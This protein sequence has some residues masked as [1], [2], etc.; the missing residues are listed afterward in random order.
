[1]HAV[2][3]QRDELG[4]AQAELAGDD[5]Y[6]ETTKENANEQ[7]PA[8]MEAPSFHFDKDKRPSDKTAQAAPAP[9]KRK[10]LIIIPLPEYQP[11]PR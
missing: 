11:E 8:I 6:R 1:M 3:I 5:F 10:P 4:D 2:E 9:A 7:A